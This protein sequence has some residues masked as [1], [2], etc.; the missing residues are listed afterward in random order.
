[1]LDITTIVWLT[2]GFGFLF[3]SAAPC[4]DAASDAA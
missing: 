3:V 2:A 4:C 1:M